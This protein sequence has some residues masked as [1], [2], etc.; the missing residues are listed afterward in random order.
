[1]R[2]NESRL[3][4]ACVRWFRLQYP[5]YAYM[6]VSVPNGVATT[7]TQGRI[8][9]REGMLAGVADLLLLVP[10]QGKGCLAIE[11]KTAKGVQRETQKLWQQEA[12][13][14]GNVYAVCRDFDQFRAVVS[15]YLLGVPTSDTEEARR[16]MREIAERY[17]AKNGS[18]GG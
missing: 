13:K 2:H 12:E 1:M 7:V 5:E 11:M 6:L 17:G 8:L 9:K 14:A 18:D 15:R 16:K 4:E 3:Q 10:R